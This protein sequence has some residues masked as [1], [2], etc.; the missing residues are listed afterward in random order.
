MENYDTK[1]QDKRVFIKLRGFSNRSY[2]GIVVEEDQDSITIKDIK[3]HL[4]RI[5]KSEM[6]LL[7]EEPKKW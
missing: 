3:G 4:V 7:Q 1:W 6:A 5:S 2:S